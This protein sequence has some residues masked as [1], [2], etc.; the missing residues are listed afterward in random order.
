M[1]LLAL[2]LRE[3]QEADFDLSLTGF[4]EL[5]HLLAAQDAESGLTDEDAVPELAQT[6]VSAIED[7]WILGNHRLLVGDATDREC[8]ERLMTVD[9]ADLIFTDPPY[10]VDY[11]GHTEE[12]LKICG[13]P[14]SDAEFKRFLHAAFSTLPKRSETR[15]PKPT[16]RIAKRGSPPV[17]VPAARLWLRVGRHK[18]RPHLRPATRNPLR[19]GFV[20]RSGRDD[21]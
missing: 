2:E 18:S 7:V 4:D 8:V 13:D 12:R 17:L 11:E 5:A 9:S 21:V 20:H 1:N 14:M 3:I 10:N 19:G 16:S 15:R 6:P